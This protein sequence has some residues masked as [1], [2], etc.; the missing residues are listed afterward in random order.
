M[1]VEDLLGCCRRH[2]LEIMNEI[3]TKDP[4][5]II[6]SNYDGVTA[7]HVA[8]NTGFEKGVDVLL[9][10]GGNVRTAKYTVTHSFDNLVCASLCT[11]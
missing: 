4:C 10:R 3:L 8:S 11:Q 9:K 5:M 7:L 2:D 6:A 1:S